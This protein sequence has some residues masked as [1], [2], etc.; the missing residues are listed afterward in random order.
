MN[1]KTVDHTITSVTG[2]QNWT[3]P[4]NFFNFCF[5]LSF[6]LS[7]ATGI[8]LVDSLSSNCAFTTDI[9]YLVRPCRLDNLVEGVLAELKTKGN[10]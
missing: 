9:M 6:N 10:S 8:D 5:L 2:Q 7:T 4:F 1:S 3:L